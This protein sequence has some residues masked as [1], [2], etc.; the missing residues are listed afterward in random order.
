MM[1]WV[2]P[3]HLGDLDVV[4][5]WPQHG[6]VQALSFKYSP[7]QK[8]DIQPSEAVFHQQLKLLKK[9]KEENE[10]CI[11]IGVKNIVFLN[12]LMNDMSYN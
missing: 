4:G 8:M 5:S 7:T 1:S 12:C 10:N 3:T 2:P 9:N 11:T 6:P